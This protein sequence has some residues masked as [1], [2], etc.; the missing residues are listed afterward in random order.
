MQGMRELGYS[1][2][3]NLFI[4]WRYADGDYSRLAGFAKEL[5]DTNPPVIVAYG[6]AA[7]RVL[8]KATAT[9]PIVVAAA[10][11]LV[12]ARALSQA[13]RVPEATSPA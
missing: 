3:K 2:G 12:G 9:I 10:V 11:D 13:W 8:Q 7:A 4:E 5:V 1:E 6:T